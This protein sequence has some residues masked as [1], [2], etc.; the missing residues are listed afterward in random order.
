MLHRNSVDFND[1]VSALSSQSKVQHSL[2]KNR[3]GAFGPNLRKYAVKQKGEFV[4]DLLAVADAGTA[5]SQLEVEASAALQTFRQNLQTLG[6]QETE[7]SLWRDL[8]TTA[9]SNAAKS[10]AAIATA[11]ANLKTL[12]AKQGTTPAE[13]SRAEIDLAAAYRKAETD[14]NSAADIRQKF[15]TMEGSYRKRWL[16]EFKS[17]LVGLISGRYAAAERMAT[18]A[19]QFHTAAARIHIYDDQKI[20]KLQRKLQAAEE[21][22]QAYR[23]RFPYDAA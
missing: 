2:A 19:D 7:Y 17:P 1:V 8:A 12:R 23:S 21:A 3:A 14:D 16:S 20:E 6:N 10:R 18:V 5:Q 15:S 9:V 11:E 13:I 4:D 22:E